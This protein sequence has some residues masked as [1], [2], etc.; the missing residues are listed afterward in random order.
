MA[1]NSVD[2]GLK[3]IKDNLSSL[4]S[5]M[6]SIEEATELVGEN[7][8]LLEGLSNGEEVDL[9]NILINMVASTINP[10][11]SNTV[12]FDTNNNLVAG[13]LLNIY[14]GMI[15]NNNDI[16]DLY[17][18]IDEHI[19]DGGDFTIDDF[20]LLSGVTMKAPTTIDT[21]LNKKLCK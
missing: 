14:K 15:E 19:E 8:H 10:V 21:E 3:T 6:I 20:F 12:M 7:T 5:N 18:T 17:D 4:D 1:L 2:G 13:G 9:N 16:V 11:L